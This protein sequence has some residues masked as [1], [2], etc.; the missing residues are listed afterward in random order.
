MAVPNTNTFSLWDVCN[1]I[2]SNHSAGMNLVQC[3]A[4]STGTFDSA[5]VGSKNSL[6]NFRNYQHTLGLV[7]DY[8]GNPYQPIR[9]GNQIWLNSDFHCT[10][11]NNGFPIP[12][13]D[14]IFIGDSSRSNSSDFNNSSFAYTQVWFYG[15]G[16]KEPFYYNAGVAANNAFGSLSITGWHVPTLN[17]LN[18]LAANLGGA[19]IAGGHLK[20]AI[21][22]DNHW[23]SPNTGADN[24]SGFTA[25]PMGMI[26]N[27][28][29]NFYGQNMWCWLSDAPISGVYTAGL[30]SY[31]SAALNNTS[32]LAN[33]GLIVRL[34]KD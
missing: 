5:Y 19:N 3:F 28:I 10:H 25:Q 29:W 22:T 15:S 12:R 8:D 14:S 16:Y 13:K 2:Y 30:L 31:N 20:Y 27:L 21:A 11:L 17:D 7:Y 1:E 26:N 18:I 23:Q 9:I 4:D 24:S 32:A 6:L 33:Y 34:I